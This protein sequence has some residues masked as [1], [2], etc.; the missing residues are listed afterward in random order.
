MALKALKDIGT[1]TYHPEL[2][3]FD[4]EQKKWAP[5]KA[6]P[7]PEG[8]QEQLTA[9]NFRLMSGVEMLDIQGMTAINQAKYAIRTCLEGWE[10]FQ[11]SNG[12]PLEFD[13]VKALA[14]M[15]SDL[16]MQ[17]GLHIVNQSVLNEE[18]SKN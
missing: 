8:D 6:G 18:Q 3:E 4:S 15:T 2:E 12:L 14:L 16:I 13:R 7:K 10:N 11:D 1:Q 5:K 9:F 17:L